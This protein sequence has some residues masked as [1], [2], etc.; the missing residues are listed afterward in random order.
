MFSQGLR[1]GGLLVYTQK[2]VHLFKCYKIVVAGDLSVVKYLKEERGR[3]SGKGFN[4]EAERKTGRKIKKCSEE[5]QQPRGKSDPC[6]PKQLK[7]VHCDQSV[8]SKSS[9]RDL[10]GE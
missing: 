2:N 8:V 6:L 5:I 10:S 4:K 7:G 3:R 9:I 1:S